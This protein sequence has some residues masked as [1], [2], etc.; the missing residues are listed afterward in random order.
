METAKTINEWLK[1]C[2]IRIVID[3]GFEGGSSYP[4][5]A[6]TEMRENIRVHLKVT[7]WLVN[8]DLPHINHNTRERFTIDFYTPIKAS[9]IYAFHRYAE[10]LV[11]WLWN[12]RTRANSLSTLSYV[13]GR[14]ELAGT[15]IRLDRRQ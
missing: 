4:V 11:E 9:Q 1:N 8:Q 12:A 15:D 3:Y 5:Y 7:P 13:I 2:R 14:V 6:A 10:A